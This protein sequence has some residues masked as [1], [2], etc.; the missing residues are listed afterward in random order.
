MK[1][2]NQLI[3]LFLCLFS[4]SLFAQTVDWETLKNA[5]LAE[6][7]DYHA[8]EPQVLKLIDWLGN[9]SL[10]HPNRGTANAYFIKWIS[11]SANVTVELHPYVLGYYKKNT[12]FMILFMAGWS[13]YVLENPAR[14]EDKMGGRLAG[15]NYFL[16]FYEKGTD[17][18]VR[19]DRKVAKLLKKR[20]AGKL[21][22]FIAK[23][24]N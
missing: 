17:F 7:K 11:G 3:F 6:E 14:K 20:E 5:E 22:E 8:I 9:H 16:D 1:N 2:F 24:N 4:T 12:D 15:I 19:K 10:D 18:G 23:K 21:E 13:K